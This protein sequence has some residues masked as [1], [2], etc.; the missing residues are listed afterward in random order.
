MAKNATMYRLQEEEEVLSFN[1]C[2]EKRKNN[3]RLAGGGEEK[4]E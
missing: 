1:F 4:A 2:A 3:N